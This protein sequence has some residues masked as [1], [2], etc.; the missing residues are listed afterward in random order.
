MRPE[1]RSAAGIKGGG[2]QPSL[3]PFWQKAIDPGARG[4]RLGYFDDRQRNKT[5]L[6]RTYAAGLSNLT[7]RRWLLSLVPRHRRTSDYLAS[8][9]STLHPGFLDRNRGGLFLD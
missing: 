1:C 3:R 4:Q 9:K 5:P 7:P 6:T 2:V 8:G